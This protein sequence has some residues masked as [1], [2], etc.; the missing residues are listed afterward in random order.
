MR[1]RPGLWASSV[2]HQSRQRYLHLCTHQVF[3][4]L[5]LLTIHCCEIHLV[6]GVDAFVKVNEIRAF[7]SS[8]PNI[9]EMP[10]PRVK[11]TT[12]PDRSN[13]GGRGVADWNLE[14]L[15]ILDLM[16]LR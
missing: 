9:N 5:S 10:P 7:I 8:M 1:Y 15:V 3:R 6:E 4:M 13:R 2:R 11:S 12:P 16:L 14:R